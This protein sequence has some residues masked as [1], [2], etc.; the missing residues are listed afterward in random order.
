MTWS[1]GTEGE[2]QYSSSVAVQLQSRSIALEQQYSSSVAVQLQSSSIALEQ[3]YRSSVAVQLQSSSTALEQQY[4]SRVAVQLLTSSIALEQKYS[5][6]V[7]V[8]L[9]SRSIAIIFI[10]ALDTGEQITSNTQPN[11]LQEIIWY[12]LHRRL[13]GPQQPSC[14]GAENLAPHQDSIS[15]PFN[16]YRMD[17]LTTLSRAIHAIFICLVN[18]G[19][20]VNVIY[21]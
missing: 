15:G 19:T 11:L 17:T 7:A 10:S 18:K 9:Y 3:Q 20:S 2:Q 8:Q 21:E 6:R 1:E 5:S 16:P 13:G 14:M 12:P 4:S